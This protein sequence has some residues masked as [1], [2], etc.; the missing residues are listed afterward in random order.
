[1]DQVRA[2][3]KQDHYEVL[4][5][6]RGAAAEEIE[7][8]YRTARETYDSDS[9]ALYSVFGERDAAVISDRIEEAYRVL[10]DDAA[11]RVYDS[12]SDVPNTGAGEIA[13]ERRVAMPDALRPELLSDVSDSFRDLEADVE[14]ND[15]D[16]SGPQLRRARLRRGFEIDQIANITKVSVKNLR[17][18]EEE[19]FSE[20][21]AGVYVRGFV[22]AYARTIGL[23]PQRVVVSYAAR[24]DEART[25][26]GR[27]R[28]MSRR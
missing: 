20:L 6:A 9:I 12:G 10:S 4:E 11:R 5:V 28:F 2:L 27:A 13:P 21:P 22:S 19:N 26:Q 1:V 18:I 14:E 25:D 17:H 8:A 24:L 3:H 15:G 16:F 7:R 23:D